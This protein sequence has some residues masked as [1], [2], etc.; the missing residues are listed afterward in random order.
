M[1][2]VPLKLDKNLRPS[3]DGCMLPLSIY[4]QLLLIESELRMRGWWLYSERGLRSDAQFGQATKS[5]GH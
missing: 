3:C 4:E 2:L 1:P 5:T